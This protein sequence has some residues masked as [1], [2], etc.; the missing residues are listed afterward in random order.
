MV[1]VVRTGLLLLLAF[2]GVNGCATKVVSVTPD[3]ADVTL[4]EDRLAPGTSTIR[5]SALLRQSGGGVVTC[6]GNEVYLVPSTPSVSKQLRAV[7]G[8]DVGYLRHGGS[9]TFGGGQEFVP[10][11]PHR[12][13]VCNA[14]G[15]FAFS[16]IKSGRW[17]I[18]TSITWIVGRDRQG[19]ALLASA[20]VADGQET[21]VVLSQ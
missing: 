17:H 4:A 12:Q 3:P 16:G 20:E 7:F 15:F 9:T 5:G 18:V 6:A 8:G 21:E 11:Q 14:Q 1:S 10:P 2:V 13:A 19:G